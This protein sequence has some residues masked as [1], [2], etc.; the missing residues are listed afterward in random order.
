MANTEDFSLTAIQ[1]E[2]FADGRVQMVVEGRAIDGSPVS[3]CPVLGKN[4]FDSFVRAAIAA[5]EKRD[6]PRH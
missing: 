6:A 3:F 5:Q 1:F 2:V 4:T